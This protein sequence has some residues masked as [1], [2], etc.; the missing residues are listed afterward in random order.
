MAKAATGK[1]GGRKPVD[2]NETKAQK[3]S[4]LGSLRLNNALK[5]IDGLRALASGSY[6]STKAQVDKI[7]TSLNDHVKAAI[8]ALK[9]PGKVPAKETITL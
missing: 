2:P 3:F 9:N 5:S 7:E 6:E 4:R 8:D 1:K